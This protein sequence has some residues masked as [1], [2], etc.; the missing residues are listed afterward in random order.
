MNILRQKIFSIFSILF[1]L[2]TGLP[3]ICVADC[4]D[5][6]GVESVSCC[7]SCEVTDDTNK[8]TRSHQAPCSN[9]CCEATKDAPLAVS[10]TNASPSYEI[11][12][13]PV[14]MEIDFQDPFERFL[15]R[16]SFS[17]PPVNLTHSRLHLSLSVLIC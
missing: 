8:E 13:N 4:C 9:A 1:L 2:I 16:D 14:L 3:A 7:T 15:T 12:S 17:H 6:L 11:D 10:L 5:E